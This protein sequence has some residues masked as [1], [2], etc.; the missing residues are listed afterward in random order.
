MMYGIVKAIFCT[1]QR[2]L[3]TRSFSLSHQAFF[4]SVSTVMWRILPGAKA[5]VNCLLVSG[6][7]LRRAAWRMDVFTMS[8]SRPEL[9]RLLTNSSRAISSSTGSSAVAVSDLKK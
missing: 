2:W 6:W 3:S 4:A 1:I 7:Q 9:P 5:G 8:A